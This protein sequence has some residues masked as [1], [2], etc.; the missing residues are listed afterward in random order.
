MSDSR[1]GNIEDYLGSKQ[2]DLKNFKENLLVF[3]DSLILECQDGPL[4]DQVFMEKCIDYVI[5]LSCTPPRVFRQVTTLVGLQLVTSLVTV[6][7]TLGGQRETTQRQLNAE[8]KKRKDGPRL[9]SLNKTLS[10][11]HEKITMAEE[12]MRK[13]FTGLFMHRYRDVDPD[14]RI[15]CI[16][17]IGSWILSYP[18]LFLQDLY[19][20][21]LGWTLNDKNAV[22]RK[23]SIMALQNCMRWMIMC[24]HLASSQNDFATV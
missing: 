18:S 14:I 4:F 16:R 19:L 2:K 15:A 1:D 8:K 11:M 7:K 5:A 3:L 22:V 21:Y 9:E 13:I 24:H 23:I 17:A 6:A 20:K 12:M 10:A